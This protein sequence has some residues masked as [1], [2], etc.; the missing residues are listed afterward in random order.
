MVMRLLI[1]IG[2]GL[3]AAIF[4]IVP[5]KGSVAAGVTMLFAPLPLMVAGL[6]FAP[7]SAIY[8]ALAGA[9]LIFGLIHE[10]YAIF[11]VAW[12][13][14]PAWWLTR[15]AWLA[16]PANEGE[17]AGADGLVWYPVGG[18]AFSAAL[19]GAG[20]AAGLVLHR[21]RQISTCFAVEVGHPV[22][23]VAPNH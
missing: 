16:R 7:S 17:Q 14:I 2:A 3:A 10:Y 13:G 11:F 12:A 15:L 5:M 18:L 20:V 8:G 9:L 21:D 22:V 4:F 23:T 19:L 6:A 1:A